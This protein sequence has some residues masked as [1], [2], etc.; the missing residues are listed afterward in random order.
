MKVL[1]TIGIA[2]AALVVVLLTTLAIPIETWRTGDQRLAPLTFAPAGGAP[3]LPQRLWID[4]DA[5]CGHGRRTDADDCLAIALLA[6]TADIRIVGI[7]TVFGNAPREAVDRTTAELVARLSTDLGQGPPVYSGSPGPLTQDGPTPR[8]AA[9]AALIAAL[10]KGQLTVVA[11]GPLTNLAAVLAERP[12]LASRVARLVAV[13]GRRPGHVFHPAEGVGAGSYFGH[14][15]VF[16]DFNFAMDIRAAALIVGAHLPLSL[17]P[18]D[19]A[20]GIEITPGD[21]DR[22]AAS[23]GA[24]AWVAERARG[25]LDYWQEDIG[26]SGFLPFDLLA[27]A[28]V[29]EP[30]R[31]RCASV[32]ASVGRDPTL[33]IPF[34]RPTALL[35]AQDGVRFEEPEAIGAALYCAKVGA[36]LKPDLLERFFGARH[37]T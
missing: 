9:H 27:A 17:I 24:G 35:V 6:R 21:L 26:R 31:F 18:Y 7:S 25:W 33:F 10:E 20:R 2:A 15:P 1:R 37:R 23:G 36:G 13:M 16:R 32:T 30:R 22:I 28:Y 12:A 8:P 5:A 14:G 34:W 3:D 19:A 11:L 29:I 4:T